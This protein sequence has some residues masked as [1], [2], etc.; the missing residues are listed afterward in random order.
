[1]AH[2]A[3]FVSGVGYGTVLPEM[4]PLIQSS[5]DDVVTVP[6]AEV[7]RTIRDLAMS[8][9]VVAEGAGALAA[10][11]ARGGRY[12]GRNVCAV[13]SGG[14]LDATLLAAILDERA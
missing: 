2:T 5:I 7:A 6:L 12:S 10:A 14:N 1:V 9:H 8:A 11:G 3:G 13:I 4:W